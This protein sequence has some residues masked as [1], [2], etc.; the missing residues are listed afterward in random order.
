MSY[1][2]RLALPD[3]GRVKATAEISL[4]GLENP[5]EVQAIIYAFTEKEK[6]GKL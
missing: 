3:T 2:P 4:Q 6:S 1:T 5:E